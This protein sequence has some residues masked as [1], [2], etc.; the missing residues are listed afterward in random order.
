MYIFIQAINYFNII[1]IIYWSFIAILVKKKL[2]KKIFM[3]IKKWA[4]LTPNRLK[5]NRLK[6]LSFDDQLIFS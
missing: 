1:M 4:E 3:A 5:K 2:A 6:I